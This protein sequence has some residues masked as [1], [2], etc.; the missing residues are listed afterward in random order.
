MVL[1]DNNSSHDRATA[2]HPKVSRLLFLKGSHNFDSRD[3][4][5]VRRDSHSSGRVRTLVLRV[6]GSLLRK[7][8]T[9]G[10][11]GE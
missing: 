8:A 3:S 2:S 6:S 1:K 7:V 11:I 10:A 9:G 4:R 5:L